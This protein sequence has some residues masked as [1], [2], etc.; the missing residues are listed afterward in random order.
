[1]PAR[2]FF[3]SSGQVLMSNSIRRPTAS[4]QRFHT[5]LLVRPERWS[6]CDD[7]LSTSGR[8]SGCS[9]QPSPLRST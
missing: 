9:R 6:D 1:V 4:M 8:P 5:S 2:L 7:M 3:S